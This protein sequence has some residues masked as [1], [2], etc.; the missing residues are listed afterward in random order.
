MVK[1]LA[2]FIS[3]KGS[4]LRTIAE[5]CKENPHKAKVS[6][7]ISN[8][9]NA[10]GLKIAKEFGIKTVVCTTAGKKMED[11]ETEIEKHLQG[12]DLICLAGFMRV[13]TPEF[14]NKW[15]GKIVNIHP[16]LLPVFKGGH[17]IEDALNYGVKITGS[18]VHFVVP[19]ID[20]GKIIAQIPVEVF[21]ND[22]IE[23]LKK[24]IQDSEKICYCK[25]LEKIL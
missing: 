21:E 22:T 11:F 25:G 23:T 2:V 1:N 6:V 13:L 15:S 18:T 14:V 12:V 17:A 16:S 10:G 20:S 5:F 19:E 9:E 7:V 4:N 3:G 24:R 8:K